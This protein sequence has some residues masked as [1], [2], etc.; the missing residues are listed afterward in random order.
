MIEFTCSSNMTGVVHLCNQLWNKDTILNWID[1]II[2]PKTFRSSP[3]PTH[4]A[5]CGFA[6]VENGCNGSICSEPRDSFTP[7][8]DWQPF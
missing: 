3:Y 4:C 1:P 6:A 7:L 5:H 2:E 8:P